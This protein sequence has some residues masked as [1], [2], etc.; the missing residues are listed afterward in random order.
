[1]TPAMRCVLTV[2]LLCESAL[3]RETDHAK[4]SQKSENHAQVKVSD[5]H[6]KGSQK[7]DPN[8]AIVQANTMA[9]NDVMN[10]K[11]PGTRNAAQAYWNQ[12]YGQFSNYV[13]SASNSAETV[14]SNTDS[15]IRV[16]KAK[17]QSEINSE[18][19]LRDYIRTQLTQQESEFD[20]NLNRWKQTVASTESGA[21]QSMANAYNQFVS[22]N[23]MDTTRM[24]E[25]ST[26]RKGNWNTFFTQMSNAIATMDRYTTTSES[27]MRNTADDAWAKAKA[28]LDKSFF[29]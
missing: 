26:S 24:R 27:A 22:A 17:V 15:A 29:C 13:N 28:E 10:T 4:G 18:S 20:A 6:A 1:M 5:N 14:F 11:L 23:L 16:D 21:M 8:H 2:A 25:G 19:S 12:K 7:T 9:F 3:R